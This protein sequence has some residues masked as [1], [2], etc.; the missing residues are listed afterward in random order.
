MYNNLIIYRNELKNKQ[1]YKYKIIGIVSE[2]IFSK[3]VFPKNKDIK[4]FL[5]NVFSIEYK[6]Y[7]MKSRSMIVARICRYI[8]LD[9]TINGIYI[10]KLLDFINEKI[11]E[12]KKNEDIKEQNPL[13]GW[14]K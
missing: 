4:E 5:L 13:S 11:N 2:V 10:K 3:D 1:V 6:E 14:I 9:E 7:V 12:F 8:F